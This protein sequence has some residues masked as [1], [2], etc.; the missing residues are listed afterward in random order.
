M[1]FLVAACMVFVLPVLIPGNVNKVFAQGQQE[2]LSQESDQK[3][4]ASSSFT[5][6][7]ISSLK[8]KVNIDLTS[9][10]YA[11]LTSS[12]NN[13]LKIV[14]NYQINH[15]SFRISPMAGTM[16]VYDSDGNIIKTSKIGNGYD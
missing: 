12:E 1:T 8:D 3:P 5:A 13:Q 2:N 9:V 16:K 14:I 15:P 4:G 7:S 6:D 11:P 10:E